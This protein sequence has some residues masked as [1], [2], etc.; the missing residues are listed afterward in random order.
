MTDMT[1]RTGNAGD[2]AADQ[3]GDR[4]CEVYLTTRDQLP[5]WY[6]EGQSIAV[7]PD[8]IALSPEKPLPAGEERSRDFL[9]FVRKSARAL[10]DR[11]I[12]SVRLRDS[13]DF[14]W[15]SEASFAFSQGFRTLNRK[16]HL[17]FTPE[18][19]QDAGFRDL[20]GV[21]AWVRDTID[22]PGSELTPDSY[23][24]ELE[25]LRDLCY[26]K[27]SIKKISG[28]ELE[29]E[30]FSGIVT[31]GRGSVNP[32]CLYILDYAPAG[33][34]EPVFISLAG[35]G[36]TFDTGGY[37][38]K[39][40]GLMKSMHSDMGGSATVA[41]ALALLALS[42]FPGRVKAYLAC[43]ENM[44]S[45]SAMRIGDIIRYRN[46]KSV[47]IDNTD[48]EGRL[49]LADALLA[50][51]GDGGYI[52]DAA[53]LTGAAKV[54]L[55]REYHAV[56]SLNDSMAENFLRAAGSVGEYAWRL[57]LEEFHLD[58]VKSGLADITN[59]VPDEPGAT[60]AAAFLAQFAENR[61]RWIHLDL[62]ASYQKTPG[63]G[64]GLGA[65]GHGIRSIARFVKD[66]W[67]FR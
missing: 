28:P 20:L 61:D 51:A 44:I 27:F 12:N 41:G 40:S 58:L 45:G 32:P 22:L 60:T 65:R 37:S 6:P 50:A 29:R 47:V 3:S 63:S 55:G 46:G 53:T 8:G 23:E 33:E 30:G 54:A 42:G 10:A 67:G 48:A 34:K 35:K 66:L 17:E 52:L 2:R 38:L 14:V 21:I 1:D 36:I 31:V 18:V 64:Y 9:R 62:A 19:A 15:D 26:G 13:R 5:S 49:V 59:S 11:G 4:T 24:K 43:A 56:L 7:L 16:Q 25:K 57:P 39:P